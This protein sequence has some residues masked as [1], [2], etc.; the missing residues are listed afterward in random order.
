MKNLVCPKC[1]NALEDFECVENYFEKDNIIEKHFGICE[2]CHTFYTWEEV[3]VL[4]EVRK[5]KEI[6]IK[7]EKENE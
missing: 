3:Y 4:T 7:E 6:N 1:E 5:I 2:K